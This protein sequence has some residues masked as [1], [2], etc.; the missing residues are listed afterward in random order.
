MG[1]D[2]EP[3]SSSVDSQ[4]SSE[5]SPMSSVTAKWPASGRRTSSWRTWSV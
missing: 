5:Y 3:D 1:L 4:D 2:V